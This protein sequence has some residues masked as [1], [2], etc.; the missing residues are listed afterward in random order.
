MQI[1]CGGFN[2]SLRAEIVELVG[3]SLAALGIPTLEEL[4]VSDR[5][6]LGLIQYF[7]GFDDLR[8]YEGAIHPVEIVGG[9]LGLTLGRH[10]VDGEMTHIETLRSSVYLTGGNCAHARAVVRHVVYAHSLAGNTGIEEAHVHCDVGLYDVAV[11][12]EE[13][14][15]DGDGILQFLALF[16]YCGLDRIDDSGAGNLHGLHGGA[17]RQ[18]TFAGSHFH[19]H[20]SSLRVTLECGIAH[21]SFDLFRLFSLD[22]RV[23]GQG[24][25]GGVL[26]R[27]EFGFNRLGLHS[28]DEVAGHLVSGDL[29][30]AGLL[31]GNQLGLPAVRHGLHRAYLVTGVGTGRKSELL[32]QG[33][34]ERLSRQGDVLARVGDV[35]M[36]EVQA[37]HGHAGL[38]GGKIGGGGRRP[39]GGHLV[40]RGRLGDVRGFGRRGLELGLYRGFGDRDVGLVRRVVGLGLGG[41]RRRAALGR[42]GEGGEVDEGEHH[43]Q[44]HE[45]GQRLAL[46]R[47]LRVTQFFKHAHTY[48]RILLALL[49]GTARPFGRR[50]HKTRSYVF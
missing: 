15:V 39:R 17:R 2:D 26:G 50:L 24:I 13:R 34:V 9:E 11:G 32:V 18:H 16:L 14:Y 21:V 29:V 1:I 35:R 31:V 5:K 42:I 7:A 33:E 19:Q 25:G 48:H 44:G 23:G 28:E 3:P 4:A 6:R 8:V 49:Q 36:R 41:V 37:H 47:V 45:D 27:G 12:A 38:G 46:E 43:H 30:L 22:L 20:A 40:L 10:D